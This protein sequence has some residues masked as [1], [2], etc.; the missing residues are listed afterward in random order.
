M[1]PEPLCGGIK[2][3]ECRMAWR[4]TR[5]AR[6][7]EGLDAMTGILSVDLRALVTQARH[8]GAGR[9]EPGE[10]GLP[11]FCCGC[12]IVHIRGNQED[13][14]VCLIRTSRSI[15]DAAR[16]AS[17]SS[18]C[19]RHSPSLASGGAPIRA[20]KRKHLRSNSDRH[21]HADSAG[22]LAWCLLCAYQPRD[23]VG[24]G[25]LRSI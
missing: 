18:A 12:A 13:P 17:D 8:S 16:G 23:H 5:A 21:K 11:L 15:Q 24:R 7:I 20:R 4:A 2:P 1:R 9:H 25:R 19:S 3:R 10:A 14:D 6:H 22:M